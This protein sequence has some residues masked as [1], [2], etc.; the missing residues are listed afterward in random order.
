MKFTWERHG[1]TYTAKIQGMPIVVMRAKNPP[2]WFVEQLFGIRVPSPERFQDP[3]SAMRLA[4]T[5]GI[6]AIEAAHN[7]LRGG[8]SEVKD[9]PALVRRFRDRALG[10]EATDL[11][12]EQRAAPTAQAMTPTQDPPLITRERAEYIRDATQKFGATGWGTQRIDAHE[13]T[14][15]GK[16]ATHSIPADVRRDTDIRLHAYIEQQRQAE[17]ERDALKAELEREKKNHA[18]T[19]ASHMRHRQGAHEK[20]VELRAKLI[21]VH[22]RLCRPGQP[23]DH[24][25]AGCAIGRILSDKEYVEEL[26]RA[27]AREAAAVEH[28]KETQRC[29]HEYRKAARLT[30][31]AVENG[32][33]QA[34]ESLQGVVVATCCNCGKVFRSARDIPD[35][36]QCVECGG[37]IKETKSP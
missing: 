29:I 4:E 31:T 28:L 11:H 7:E 5:L 27:K 33:Q 23:A 19:D 15:P 16:R 30:P 3:E 35:E 32:I 20:I 24:D 13:L 2:E 8:G 12:G 21:E 36:W 25:F 14:E 18:D 37:L 34:L 6:A 26:K 17:S 1:L 9:E 10:R 22:D